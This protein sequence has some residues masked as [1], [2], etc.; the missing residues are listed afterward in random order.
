V[1][2][3]IDYSVPVIA[4]SLLAAVGMDLTT[5]DFGRVRRQPALVIAGLAGPVLLLPPLAAVLAW[6]A[7][8]H[9]HIAAGLLLIAV[10]PVGGISNVFSYLAGASAA[11]SVSLTGLSCLFAVVTIPIVSAV[12]QTVLDRP[13]GL[14]APLGTL[15]SQLFVMLAAPVAL[16]VWV[17]HRWPAFAARR[18]QLFQRASFAGVTVLLGVIIFSDVDRFL[19]SLGTAVPLI[20]A[21]V[22]SAFA[23]GWLTATAVTRDPRDRFTLAAEF[24]TRNIGVALG[25]AVTVLGRV[26]FAQFGATYFLTEVPM[27]LAAA[28]IFK[29]STRNLQLSTNN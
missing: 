24:G 9:P 10:C 12:L 26:E 1:Q 8:S 15:A 28:A 16:G 27:M 29:R 25:I 4:F 6:M 3:F 13:L 14:T 2:A 5:E 19:A 21:F 18:R 20:V 7:G 22:A 11:L 23:I 17:R